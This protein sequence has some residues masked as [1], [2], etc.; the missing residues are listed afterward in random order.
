M[1]IKIIKKKEFFENLEFFKSNLGLAYNY[2]NLECLKE[3][4]ATVTNETLQEKCNEVCEKVFNGFKKC[5]EEADYDIF[6][7]IACGDG[8]ICSVASFEREAGEDWYI[9]AVTTRIGYRGRGLA[10][11]VLCAGLKELKSRCTLH[12]NKNNT[13]AF[14]L[15]KK[16]GFVVSQGTNPKNAENQYLKNSFFMVKEYAKDLEK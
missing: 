14:N 6:L 1:E 2:D 13:I 12:V 7:A 9:D 15:Y 16:L 5:F 10:T 4:D 3:Y 11:K 8:G